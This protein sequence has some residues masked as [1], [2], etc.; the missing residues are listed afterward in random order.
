[1]KAIEVVQENG[2]LKLAAGVALPTRAKLAVLVLEPDEPGGAQVANLA[3]VSGAFDFL[4]E[5][6]ELYS[7]RDLLPERINPQFRK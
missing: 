1:M 5:E 6:P 7:D 4:Q 3:A 2:V